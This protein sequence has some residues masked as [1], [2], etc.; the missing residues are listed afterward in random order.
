ML[1][2]LGVGAAAGAAGAAGRPL[3]S[4]A[5]V[6]APRRQPRDQADVGDDEADED[7]L[8]L[9]LNKDFMEQLTDRFGHSSILDERTYGTESAP[10]G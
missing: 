4:P 10:G 2:N 3:A 5:P 8:T 1:H 6:P 7:V 9:V